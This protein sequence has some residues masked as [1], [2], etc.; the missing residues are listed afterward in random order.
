MI[1]RNIFIGGIIILIST[2]FYALGC[3]SEDSMVSEFNSDKINGVSLVASK[4]PLDQSHIDPILN[5]KSNYT[6]LMPFGF[7]QSK[8]DPSVIFN[9]DRQWYGETKEGIEQYVLEL[10][11]NNLSIM[12]KPQLWIRYGEFTGDLTM[13]SEDNWELFEETYTAFILEFATIADQLQIEIFCIGTELEQFVINRPEY[14]LTLIE[15]VKKVYS[16]KI[17]YAANWNEYEKV[18]FW[19]E[20]DFIGIDAYFPLNDNQIPSIAD[21]RLGWKVH[22]TNIE[23]IQ[24]EFNKQVI[25]TEYGYRSID[26]S[27]REPWNSDRMEGSVNLVGQTNLLQALFD[28]FWNENWFAGG[29][30]W[31]WYIDHPNAGGLEDNRFT[32]QNKPAE[33]LLK[34]HF[35]QYE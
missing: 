21:S 1:K 35:Q 25:F 32:P 16:G 9:T 18:P 6:T 24:I 15:E 17:T 2:L 8:D 19:G 12:L 30:I 22:K 7:I 13:E 28:E 23:A 20:L 26:F 11:N 4:S 29:F 34:K 31:K 5:I 27:A 10:K 33:S 14:W 3:V